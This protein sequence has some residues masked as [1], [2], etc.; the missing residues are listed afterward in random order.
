MSEEDLESYVLGFFSDL[1]ASPLSDGNLGNFLF[2]SS[3]VLFLSDK[4]DT[5]RS[6]T[7]RDPH[8]S[9]LFI[10]HMISFLCILITNP[11]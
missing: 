1:C 5:L 6:Y 2:F 8:A 9:F 11:P 4:S 3:F 7:F 10:R